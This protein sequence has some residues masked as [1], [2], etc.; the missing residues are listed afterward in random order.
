MGASYS[1]VLTQ[2]VQ[3]AVQAPARGR[4]YSNPGSLPALLLVNS[5]DGSSN[6]TTVSTG[7]S[8][9]GSGNAFDSVNIG[10]SAT[11]IYSNAHYA[12]GSLAG[13]FA[14]GASSVT[15]LVSWLTASVGIQP[16][17]W[18]R[19]YAFF[20]AN[21]A[22]SIRAF[23]A[24]SNGGQCGAMQVTTSGTLQLLNAA[25]GTVA[26]SSNA[27]PLNQWFRVEGFIVGSPNAGQLSFSLFFSPDAQ[28]P[29]ETIT[30][31]ATQSTNNP[32]AAVQFGATGSAANVAQFWLD[33]I[34]IS[35]TGPLGPASLTGPPS[36]GYPVRSRIVPPGLPPRG[37]TSSNPGGKVRNPTSGPVFRQAVQPARA[38]IPRPRAGGLV[39][40]NQH[41]PPYVPPVPPPPPPPVAPAVDASPLP[42]LIT[43][44]PGFL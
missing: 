13:R 33:S 26:T 27:V 1:S 40:S 21:P 22:S 7:N 17:I 24:L 2:P 32:V 36:L 15:D 6:N 4:V 37:R 18:F 28:I 44:F 12:H 3:A 14:T 8:G 41:T 10:A 19:V 9:G 42:S 23:R 30:S 11:L 5:F 35:N 20:T 39:V 25:G 16:K 38:R 29:V 43:T 34:G 31:S